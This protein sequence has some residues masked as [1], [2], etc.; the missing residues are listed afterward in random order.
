MSGRRSALC[1]A[2]ALLY[3]PLQFAV[4]APL[5]MQQT[6]LVRLVVL[7]PGAAGKSTFASEL[8]EATG[9]PRTELD[10]VFWSSDLESTDPAEWTQIQKR[11][12]SGDRWILDGD[13]GPYDVLE[14]RLRRADTIV[15]LDTQTWRCAWRALRR[16]RERRD[17]WRWLLTWRRVYR[18]QLMEAIAIHAGAAE[19]L[20]ATTPNEVK[21]TMQA[22][23]E[24]SDTQ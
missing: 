21:A 18:P 1:A 12:T 9:I 10:E 8:S 22:L 16:S 14:A 17:F 7:G 3:P 5:R 24:R 4:V 6:V 11:L 20:I 23:I 19:L 15:L 13:L 2:A